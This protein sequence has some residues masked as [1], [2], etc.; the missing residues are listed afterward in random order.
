MK[1]QMLIF[2]FYF[3]KTMPTM[4]VV[5]VLMAL[6]ASQSCV[7]KHRYNTAKRSASHSRIKNEKLEGK[8]ETLQATNAVL[9]SD[10]ATCNSK[11]VNLSGEINILG[12][13]NQ[14]YYKDHVLTDEELLAQQTRLVA[15]QNKIYWQ[16]QRTEALREK[17]ATALNIYK[18]DELMI[19]VR[20][21]KIHIS[22]QEDF[23]FPV[24]SVEIIS[25]SKMALKSVAEILNDNRENNV[26]I[27]GHTDVVSVNTN[28]YPD[29]W[30]LSTARAN[31]IAHVMV[32]EYGIEPGRIA[33]IG[34]SQYAAMEEKTTRIDHELNFR[35]EI[36]LEPKNNELMDLIYSVPYTAVNVK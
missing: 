28:L 31:A 8:V 25:R 30:A 14:P 18:P 13:A 27:E 11:V 16:Q 21:G 24:G 6:A 35:T 32:G 22:M 20:N 12:N 3:F 10:G 29:N 34:R 17:I 1:K 19:F 36:I 26:V 9:K 23:V 2:K 4:A 15:L 5:M 7:T 33:A